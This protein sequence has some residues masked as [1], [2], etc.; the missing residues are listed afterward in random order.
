MALDKLAEADAHRFLDDAGRVHVARQLEQ[1]GAFVLRV[2]NAGEPLWR[3]P[4]DRRD[5]RDALDIVDGGRATVEAGAR[6]ERRLEARLALLALK[7]FEHRHLFAADVG[8]SAAVH[9]Q[10]EVVAGA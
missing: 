9:E 3:A 10:I 2:A 4:K 5:D 7:A 6:R 8:A 1:L